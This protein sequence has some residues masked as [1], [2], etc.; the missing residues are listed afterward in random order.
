MNVIRL[1]LRGFLVIGAAAVALAG[2]A[3]G[4]SSTTGNAGSSGGDS[5]TGAAARI[6]RVRVIASL[7][8]VGMAWSKRI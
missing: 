4:G 2:A 3:C 1:P 6:E 5:S 8:I 7:L